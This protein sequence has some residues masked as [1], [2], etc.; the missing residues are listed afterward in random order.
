MNYIIRNKS[1]ITSKENLEPLYTFKNFPVFFGCVD[2]DSREDVRADMSFAICPE[3]GVIQIDKLLP[4]EVLYQAQ[5]MDG[6]GPT[7]QAFYKDFTKYIAKQSPKKI[8]EI[9]GG[10]GTLGEVFVEETDDTIWTIVEPNPLRDSDERIKVIPA[11]FDERFQSEE[12]YDA[13]VFSHTLEHA[14]DPNEFLRA[15]A[16]YLPEGGRLIFAYPQLDVWLKNKYTTALNFEHNMLLTDYFVDYLLAVHG[17]RITDKRFYQE[18]SVYYTA[19]K[20][21]EV[22]TLPFLES[23]YNE[24]KDLFMEFISYHTTIVG[25][26]NKQ[27]NSFEGDVY[28][29]GGHIF[30]QYLLEFGLRGDKITCILDNSKLK[31]GKRLYGSRLMVADPEILR[32]VE[33][34]A[35][36]LKVGPYRDEIFRQLKEINKKVEIF[37]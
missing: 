18:H 21:G 35:V 3:T 19:E 13:V 5:H 4:L 14:Y 26:L 33:K 22:N 32:D 10:K 29:F 20:V 31:Q 25:Q 30:S 1:V 9:G 6:T 28:L 27:I 7:W 34:P 15:I 8:L 36:I 16:S 11:F 17:F 2:H 12:Q 23:K 24:Y 37:E